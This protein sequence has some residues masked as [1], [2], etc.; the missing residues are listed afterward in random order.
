[1]PTA[2]CGKSTALKFDQFCQALEQYRQQLDADRQQADVGINDDRLE[3]DCLKKIDDLLGANQQDDDD[4]DGTD[5]LLD[6][7]AK[8]SRLREKIETLRELVGRAAEPLDDRLH[9][10]ANEVR[11]QYRLA[12]TIAWV[13]DDLA[14]RCCSLAAVQSVP[15]MDRPAAADAGRRLARSG[16]RQVRP[17][18]PLES[19]D[20]MREL[21]EAMNAMTARFQ[22]IRDDL[23]RQ[24]QRADQ[25]SRAQRAAGERRL[26]G[27]RRGTR[28]QQSAGVDRAVQRIAR[29][30]ACRFA[31]RCRRLAGGRARRR[32]QLPRNDP[33]GSVPLQTDHREAAR[34][35]ADGR[36]GA[37]SSP[38]CASW[39]PA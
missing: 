37:A 38:I 22:E 26:S 6:S 14:Q 17:S 4:A 18:H 35:L 8:V 33:E 12:I 29:R 5:W 1:M 24:V 27:G 23:D 39:W 31:R 9:E 25:A 30:P 19:D 20:E 28:N 2:C 34:L 16:G 7:E 32:S 10:L 13:D 3:R 21:A 36:S 11:T 15:Q